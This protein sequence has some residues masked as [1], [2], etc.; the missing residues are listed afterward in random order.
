MNKKPVPDD[1]DELSALIDKYVKGERERAILKRRLIDLILFEPLAEE[2]N[3]SVRGIQNVVYRA[4]EQLF[5]NL[6]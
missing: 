5:R 2:F 6:I 3:M 1:N 4:E